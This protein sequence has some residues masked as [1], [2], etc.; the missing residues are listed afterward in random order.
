[1]SN[2]NA[3]A[4][5]ADLPSLPLCPASERYSY[6]VVVSSASMPSSCRGVYKRIAVLKVDHH[7]HPAGFVPKTIR[8]LRGVTI[9]RTWEKLAVGKTERCAYRVALAAANELIVE[10]AAK[11]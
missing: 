2:A 11:S 4:Q 6:H 8:E 7:E 9:E 5:V 3:T 1:M 10:L